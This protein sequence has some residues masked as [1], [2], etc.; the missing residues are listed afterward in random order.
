MTKVLLDVSNDFLRTTF[1]HLLLSVT[2]DIFMLSL[3]SN[4]DGSAINYS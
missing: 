3:T 4:N 1:I 2:A